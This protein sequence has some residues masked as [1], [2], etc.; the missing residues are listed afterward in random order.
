[1]NIVILDGPGQVAHVDA[2]ASLGVGSR[3]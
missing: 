2:G 1:V 3:G